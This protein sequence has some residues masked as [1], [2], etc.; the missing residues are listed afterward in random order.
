[1]YVDDGIVLCTHESFR[2]ELMATLTARYDPLTLDEN[3]YSYSGYSITRDADDS[4]TIT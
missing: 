4:V 1:M 3:Y 2:L